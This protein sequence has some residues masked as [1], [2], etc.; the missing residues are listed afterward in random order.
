MKCVGILTT[1]CAV[2]LLMVLTAT[3][4]LDRNES[5]SDEEIESGEYNEPTMEEPATE[6][7]VPGGQGESQFEEA[8]ETAIK[9]ESEVVEESKESLEEEY[10][11]AEEGPSEDDDEPV[12]EEDEMDWSEEEQPAEDNDEDLGE[13]EESP[14]EY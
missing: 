2:S 7:S 11:A 10:E 4:C 14:E 12:T 1:V 6:Q 13:E 9:E 5:L 3:G 8:E